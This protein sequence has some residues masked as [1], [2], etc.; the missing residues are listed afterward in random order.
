MT[1]LAQSLHRDPAEVTKFFGAELGAQTTWNPETERAIVNGAHTTKDLQTNVFKYIEKFVLCPA[2]RLPETVYKIKSDTI[3][4]V[5]SA[6]GAKEMVDMTHKLTVFILKQHKSSKK[7]SKKDKKDKK[8]KKGDDDDEDEDGGKDKKKKKKVNYLP[9]TFY[10]L[11]IK[12]SL[13]MNIFSS[14]FGRIKRRRRQR[15]KRRKR[16]RRRMP[17]TTTIMTMMMTMMMRVSLLEVEMMIATRRLMMTIVTKQNPRS[18]Q[19]L[20]RRI[21]RQPKMLIL[22]LAWTT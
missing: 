10:V 12:D 4:H 5:C 9:C 11:K 3:Y 18:L 16:R 20:Q 22:L 13:L 17:T 21:A 19:S 8:K 6:C 15:K 2:C 1:L 7:D 14:T